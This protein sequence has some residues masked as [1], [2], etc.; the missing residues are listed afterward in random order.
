M[1]E[2]DNHEWQRWEIIR[3]KGK[4]IYAVKWMMYSIIFMIITQGTILLLNN[5]SISADGIFIGLIVYMILGVII[6]IIRW[7]IYEFR[8]RD[9]FIK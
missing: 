4:L 2:L 8:Y 3:Q 6:S 7:K 5:R 9:R 1:K